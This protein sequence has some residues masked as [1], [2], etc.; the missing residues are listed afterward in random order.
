[1]RRSARRG[2]NAVEFALTVPILLAVAGGAIELGWFM[3]LKMA[4]VDATREAARTAA[5]SDDDMVPATRGR[6]AGELAWAAADVVPVVPTFTLTTSGACPNAM[7]T[8][9]GTMPYP[10]L[11][12]ALGIPTPGTVSHTVVMRGCNGGCGC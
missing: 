8:A 12:T 5:T 3:T 4:M 11:W 9:V 1:M 10:G 7:W 6:V 2:S